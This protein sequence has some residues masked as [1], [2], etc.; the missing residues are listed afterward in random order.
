MLYFTRLVPLIGYIVYV[1]TVTVMQATLTPSNEL[2]TYSSAPDSARFCNRWEHASAFVWTC[3]C[4]L[5][6]SVSVSF[7]S[8]ILFLHITN[9]T[10]PTVVSNTET[11]YGTNTRFLFE[12]NEVIQSSFVQ[13][14]PGH[15][16]FIQVFTLS[17]VM[18]V[19]VCCTVSTH[20]ILTY[21]NEC[22]LTLV[23]NDV[24]AFVCKYFVFNCSF[25]FL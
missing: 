15:A 12:W 21:S 18:I 7:S 6:K 17:S 19:L 1:K 8:C 24:N 22:Y 14:D 16:E 9:D 11:P 20:T 25:F 4:H 13:Q 3:L 2:I 23:S 5:T 10:C